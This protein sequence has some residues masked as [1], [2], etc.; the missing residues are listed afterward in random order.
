VLSAPAPYEVAEISELDDFLALGPEWDALLDESDCDLPFLRHDWFRLWWSH[1]GAGRRLSV[2]TARRSGLLALALPM[3][4]ERERW[5]PAA[6]V[7]LRSLTNAHSFRFQI[8]LRRGEEGSVRAAWDFLARRGRPWHMLELER[9]PTGFPADR[10]L[11]LAAGQT[12]RPVGVWEGGTSPYLTLQGTWEAYLGSLK[13]KLRSNLRNRLKRLQKLGPVSYELVTT[14]GESPAALGDAFAIEGSGWKGEQKSAIGMDP[15]LTR[16]YTEW[17]ELAAE[18]GWLRL[19]F[20]RLGE[21]RV[22][23]EYNLEYKRVLYC[24]KIGYDSELHPYSPGQTLKAAVLERAFR[25]G[26]REYDFLGVMDEAKGDW[27]STGR[28]FN[29]VYLYNGGPQ[30]RVHHAVKFGLKPSLKRALGR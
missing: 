11:M 19:W 28:P 1:F 29:W 7:K 16:F 30:S 9:F 18:R 10:E 8:P 2:L 21:R 25:E 27:T 17:G 26:V 12:G 5:F 24:M 13:P 20:L 14:R 23:F 15:T 4:E 6:L 22:A 3:M